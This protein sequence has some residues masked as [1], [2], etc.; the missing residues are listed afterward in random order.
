MKMP[1]RIA[2]SANKL[3]SGN[4]AEGFALQCFSLKEAMFS[5]YYAFHLEY[6]KPVK[7]AMFF[8]CIGLS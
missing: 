6:P 5:T 2:I 7:I 1:T 3:S 8:L 4:H